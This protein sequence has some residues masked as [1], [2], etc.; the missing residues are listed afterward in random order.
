[1]ALRV[2]TLATHREF[3]P[4]TYK[5][6]EESQF[7]KSCHSIVTGLHSRWGR[8]GYMEAALAMH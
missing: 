4:G 7:F 2:K 5:M 3:D 8:G 1:M 6:Q